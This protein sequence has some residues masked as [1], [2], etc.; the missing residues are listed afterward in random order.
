[1]Q[2]TLVAF[3]VLCIKSFRFTELYFIVY[4]YYMYYLVL[5]LIQKILIF[6]GNLFM[7]KS[8][9]TFSVLCIIIVWIYRIKFIYIV[10]HKKI[11]L[12]VA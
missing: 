7:Q 1:M 12:V 5:T 6:I 9:V 11:F 4:T 3:P 10:Y 8:L 2:E